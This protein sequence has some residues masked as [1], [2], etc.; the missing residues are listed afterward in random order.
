M[1]E[2]D[3]EEFERCI[4]GGGIAIFPAD[5]VYGLAADPDSE[6]AVAR[7]N[8]LKQRDPAQPSGVMFFSLE[9]ALAALDGLG[10][11]TVA[12]IERLLPGPL[13]LVLPNEARGFPLACGD[14][15]DRLGIR[16]PDLT[17]PLAPLAAVGRPVLQSSANLHGGS[18]PRRL[19]DVPE[20]LRAAADLVLDG[21]ELPG[22]PS[23]VV[24]LSGYETGGRYEL[25]REGALPAD[26]L[27]RV[28]SQGL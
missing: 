16:V 25:L 11:A 28:L 7:L 21:G 4:A 15:P 19:V 24:D 14:R 26:A 5:T 27:R 8:E 23:T 18:D 10:S 9:P 12:A 1:T 17:G 2:G 13:T 20:Q 6:R 3:A 22:T